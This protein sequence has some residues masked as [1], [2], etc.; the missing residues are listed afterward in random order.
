M[1]PAAK[2]DQSYLASL[3]SLPATLTTPPYPAGKVTS[4]V[5]AF[6]AAATT[7]TPSLC[8]CSIASRMP[9]SGPL[10]V[11]L[12]LTTSAPL[13]AAQRIPAAMSGALPDPLAAITLTGISAQPEHVPSPPRPLLARAATTPATIVP[14]P[15]SSLGSPS[16]LT[17]SWP[18]TNEP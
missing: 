16:A 14:W 3:G 6:P 18:W 4:A 11:K 10:S 2:A 12:M 17:K 8:A 7:S 9:S 13:S 1:H 5:P 15:W